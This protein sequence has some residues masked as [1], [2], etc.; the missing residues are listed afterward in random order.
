MVTARLNVL[1]YEKTLDTL[2]YIHKKDPFNRKDESKSIIEFLDSVHP[3]TR[4]ETFGRYRHEAGK[5]VK[6]AIPNDQAAGGGYRSWDEDGNPYERNE[7]VTV[8]EAE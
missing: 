7:T 2:R 8:N 4:E 3:D 5:N 6:A 1:Q